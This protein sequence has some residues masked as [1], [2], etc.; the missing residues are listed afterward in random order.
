MKDGIE[1]STREEKVLSATT[2]NNKSV[3]PIPE[4]YDSI[5]PH[6]M[7]KNCIDAI[8]FYKKAFYIK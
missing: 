3:N 1:M 8:E 7:V 4:G 6:L 2:T 5:T